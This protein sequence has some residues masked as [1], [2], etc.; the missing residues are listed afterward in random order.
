MGV[1]AA[2]V[3]ALTAGDHTITAALTDKA[4]NSNST[5][6]EVEVNLTAPVL[7]ID[8]VS[9]DDVI[10]SSEKT[11][12]L[13][14]TG[15]ASGLAAGAVVTVMLNGK[16]YSATVDTNGQWTTT[17]P[18]SEVGQL[19]EAL[20]TVSASATDSV[21]N[22]T[23]T[24]HTVNVESVLP[25]VIIN[26]V[27]GDDVINAAELAT[28]QTISGTVVNAE[29]G[30]TV[31]VSV[32]GHNY[33]ATVQSDL[34]WSVSVPES[35]LTALGNGDL[36]VTA[37]VTNGVGNSGSGERDITIDANLPGLRVDTV[38]G[39][40]VINSIEHGQNLIIT[41]SSDGLTAGTALTVTVNGKTYAATVLAGGFGARRSLLRT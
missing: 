25:G 17:V 20:Y 31:T 39:D 36:T 4:G 7:T 33:T 3:S 11:Q 15:T 19:G 18:A 9:G 29:A 26:T 2:D 34:T 1:P 37:S 23:S 21:G 6:H 28:G 32:G 40:D 41:G 38:V 24:S 5:T 8:T 13:T 10:N 35:V 14:I 22:S 27:A 16:A 30:N 12:D